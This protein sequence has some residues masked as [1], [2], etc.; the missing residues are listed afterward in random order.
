MRKTLYLVLTTL[1]PLAFFSCN[2]KEELVFEHEKPQFELKEE[3]ILIEVIVPIETTASEDIYIVG[4]FNG[5]ASAVGDLQYKLQRSETNYKWG[6]Y[7][8]PS[9]FISGKTLAAGYYFHSGTQGMERTLKNEAVI[10]YE[11]T[12]IGERI[13]VNVVRWEAYF[14]QPDTPSVE[15]PVEGK[16]IKW[17]QVAGNWSAMAIYAWGP[18]EGEEAFG[19]WPGAVVTP[20][21]DGWYRVVLPEETA[22][23]HVIFNNAGGGE[24]FNADEVVDGDGCYE[25]TTTTCTPVDC[26]DAPPAPSGILVK[27]KQVTGNWAAMAVY[28]WGGSPTE[29][30]LGT[31]PGK[32]VTAD[33]GGWYSI[34]IP[35][36]QTAG[37]LIINNTLG[38]S[39]NQLPDITGITDNACYEI[40]TDALTFSAVDCQ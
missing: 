24:Q 1:L 17:K 9:T 15:P 3:A 32:I 36:G 13:N 11:T 2:E 8:Y 10:H 18:G 33:A 31:W 4:E 5:G 40:D 21:A 30:H 22:L 14:R 28:A 20:D 35:E 29:E 7:L 27:W 6:I 19:G 26:G 37:N 25:I 39:G 16:V 38:G 23:G 34:L 12:E